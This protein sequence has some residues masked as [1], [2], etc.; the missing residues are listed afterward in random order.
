MIQVNRMVCGITQTLKKFYFQFLEMLVPFIISHVPSTVCA[1]TFLMVPVSANYIFKSFFSHFHLMNIEPEPCS[2]DEK[3]LLI[4]KFLENASNTCNA[5]RGA[6]AQ[7]ERG[8]A[9]ERWQ[10]GRRP[11][12]TQ[13]SCQLSIC[14]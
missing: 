5:S 12:C 1:G 8:Y 6:G 14:F 13:E 9:R 2:E 3:G 4:S 10:G 7:Q 11:P